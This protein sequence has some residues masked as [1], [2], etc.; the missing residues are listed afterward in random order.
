MKDIFETLRANEETAQR[1]FE[2]EVSILSILNFRDLFQR[3]LTEIR[4]KFGVP[5][6]WLSMIGDS[7]VSHLIQALET[8]K[9]LKE[10]LN[11]ID[12]ETLLMLTNNDTKPMLINGDLRPYHVLLPP[13][14]MYFIR[15]L[16]IAPLSLAGE[17]IGSLN[18][19]DISRLRYRPGMDTRLLERLAV[20]VSLC[21][22][23]VTAHEKIRWL[24]HRDPL[25][26]LLNRR[27]MENVLQREYKRAS[28]YKTPLS[29]AFLDLDDF[30][31][32]NDQYGH[33]GGDELLRYVATNLVS[34]T[35]DSDLVARYAGDEFVIILPGVTSEEAAR[36]V[37][38]L[39][40]HFQG[41]PVNLAGDSLPVSISF[42]ISSAADPGVDNPA[43]L[44]RKADEMLYNAKESKKTRKPGGQ[45]LERS[46][47]RKPS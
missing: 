39:K 12:R 33:N 28:R 47:G 6:V 5:Y 3:L 2:I 19:A 32:I 26:G 9:D 25:T 40:A 36:L 11:I 27:V 4:E 29:L 37:E 8:S 17:L 21:L 13:G 43:S 1:F 46:A 42:G 44:L 45:R 30:K 31:T 15:S 14:Q 38:R 7:E 35:R 20:K 22:S 41:N 23:N 34:V 16:A 10:R 18:Q 24:A